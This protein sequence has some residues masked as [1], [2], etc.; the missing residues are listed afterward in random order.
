MRDLSK[1]HERG[2]NFVNEAR[3]NDLENRKI[4]RAIFVQKTKFN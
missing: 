4:Q 2:S 3:N 1:F